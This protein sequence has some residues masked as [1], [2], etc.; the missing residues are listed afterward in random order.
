MPAQPINEIIL[1]L[2][3]RH[4]SGAPPAEEAIRLFHTAVTIL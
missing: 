4:S 2:G 1:P 3:A